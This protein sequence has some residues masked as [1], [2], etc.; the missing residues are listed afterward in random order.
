MSYVTF[1]AI[2]AGRAGFGSFGGHALGGGFIGRNLGAYTAGGMASGYLAMAWPTLQ[3]AGMWVDGPHP[4][5]GG[6]TGARTR[7][8]DQR[9][10]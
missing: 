2:I 7:P 1:A 4:G 5:S 3:P 8:I 9:R 6:T 10:R